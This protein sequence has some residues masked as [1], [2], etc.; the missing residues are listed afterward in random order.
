MFNC[1]LDNNFADGTVVAANLAVPF[2]GKEFTA[3]VNEFVDV[4]ITAVSGTLPTLEVQY[5][6]WDFATVAWTVK[7]TVSG[8]N[9]T[10]T[11]SIL[12]RRWHAFKARA[13]GWRD[14]AELHAELTSA[15]LNRKKP[16]CKRSCQVPHLWHLTVLLDCTSASSQFGFAAPVLWY[17][18]HWQRKPGSVGFGFPTLLSRHLWVPSCNRGVG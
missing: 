3:D 7:Q 8:L 11:T 1:P 13:Y 15:R 6:V 9:S 16:G 4:T 18:W 17:L 5:E 10:G 14:V 12:A 2:Y